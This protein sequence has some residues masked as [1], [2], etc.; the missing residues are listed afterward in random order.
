[1]IKLAYIIILF[2][3]WAFFAGSETAFISTSRFKLNNLKKKGKKNASIACYLLERPERLLQTSLVG[4]NIALVLSA[5]LTSL[6][7]YDLFGEA[8]PV[9]S[10]FVLTIASLVCCEIIPKNFAIKNGIKLTLLFAFP[11]YVFYFIFFPI[12]KVFT[13][14]TKAVMKIGGI[15]GT[16]RLPT[17]FKRR[18][19]VEIFLT[20]SLA[21]TLTRDERRFFVDSLDFGSKVLSDILVPLVDIDAVPYDCRVKDCIGIIQEKHRSYLPV[22]TERIDNIIGV[23]YAQDLVT[24]NRSLPAGPLM[25]KP[26]YM[27]ESKNINEL[28]RELYETDTPVVFV[29]DEYG[30]VIGMSTLYDIGEEIIGKII[31]GFEDKKSLIVKLRENEWLCDGD[32][33]IDDLKDHIKFKFEEGPYTT[34]NGMISSSLGRVPVK[35]DELILGEYSFFVEKST[36]TKALLIKIS[37]KESVK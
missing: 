10:I 2:L 3:L 9:I 29:V 28:Y 20:A 8:K 26:C 16:G 32:A 12:G 18:E 6:L 13:F 27:P 22:Y 7:L 17:L 21:K 35:G 23:L 11:L 5:N 30:G 25:K 34:L 37:K 14:I 36:L 31:S 15:S 19:D 24:T 1:M 33:E 4:T